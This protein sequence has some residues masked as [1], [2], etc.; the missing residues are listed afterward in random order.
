[1]STDELA[2]MIAKA[3]HQHAAMKWGEEHGMH[4]PPESIFGADACRREPLLIV[5]LERQQMEYDDMERCYSE[6]VIP[7]LIGKIEQ[8]ERQVTDM[9]ATLQRIRSEVARPEAYADWKP[10]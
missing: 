3:K 10:A 5:A 6:V 4:P 2:T 8:L 7:G 1:M 9:E